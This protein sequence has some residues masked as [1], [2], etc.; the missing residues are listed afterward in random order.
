MKY[1]VIMIYLYFIIIRYSAYLLIQILALMPVT[2]ACQLRDVL[3]NNMVTFIA[4]HNYIYPL[5]YFK[6][7][8]TGFIFLL[9]LNVFLIAF[10]LAFPFKNDAITILHAMFMNA[11]VIL[12][13]SAY[14]YFYRTSVYLRNICDRFCEGKKTKIYDS[15][16]TYTHITFSKL[17]HRRK[18]V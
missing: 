1:I 3:T 11:I 7:Q 13:R 9:E 6:D 12:Q 18:G 10:F 17:L 16:S 2:T 8:Q 14:G 5:V 4:K 15:S